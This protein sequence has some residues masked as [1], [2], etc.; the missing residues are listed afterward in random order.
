MFTL[1]VIIHDVV[2]AVQ[3][4]SP[5]PSRSSYINVPDIIYADDTML[6]HDDLGTLQQLLHGV[7]Q[8]GRQYGL[9][10]NWDKVELLRARGDGRVAGPGGEA[11]KLPTSIFRARIGTK[12]RS[13]A[14]L[15][16]THSC[17]SGYEFVSMGRALAPSPIL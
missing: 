1:T 4:K 15:C 14:L 11:A 2:K 17:S 3:E 7:L 8:F 5:V 12:G 9:E 13:R 16:W 6:M 10:I